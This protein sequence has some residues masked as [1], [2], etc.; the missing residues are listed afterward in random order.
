MLSHKKAHAS[1]GDARGTRTLRAHNPYGRTC[2]VRNWVVAALCTITFVLITASSAGELKLQVLALFQ[3]PS[4]LL[5]A[6]HNSEWRAVGVPVGAAVEVP[7][8]A[9][10]KVP[11]GAAVGT[12]TRQARPKALTPWQLHKEQGPQGQRGVHF[13]HGCVHK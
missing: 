6:V 3:S 4:M 2:N 1:Y 5:V 11:V 13:A 10:V 9:T 7:L 8:G 12:Y